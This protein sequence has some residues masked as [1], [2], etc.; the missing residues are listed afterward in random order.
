M[1]SVLP[2]VASGLTSLKLAMSRRFTNPGIDLDVPIAVTGGDPWLSELLAPSAILRPVDPHLLV[3][4]PDGHRP[5]PAISPHIPA[6][7][8]R[9]EGSPSVTRPFIQHHLTNP[10]TFSPPQHLPDD[11]LELAMAASFRAPDGQRGVTP[12]SHRAHREAFR[13]TAIDVLVEM[14]TLIGRTPPVDDSVT[15]VCVSNRPR[16]IDNVVENFSRQTYEAKQLVFVSNSDSFDSDVVRAKLEHLDAVIVAAPEEHSLGE[17]LNEAMS[18]SDS[19]FIAKFDDDDKYGADYLTD[20]INAH[21]YARAGVVG[22]H[23]YHAR[24]EK[25]NSTFLRFPGHEFG[26]TSFLAG[27]TLVIDRKATDGISFSHRSVGEDTGF[28]AECRRRGIDVF[29]ADRFNYLQHR[30]DD[31]TWKVD[32]RAFVRDAIPMPEASIDEE[33]W[34]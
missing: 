33:I 13:S 12:S 24:V 6:C 16:Q 31:N 21:R 10:I 19:R 30:G 25:L 5:D 1:S 27:G 3:V 4:G 29:S 28:L 11:L 2:R 8:Y 34:V 9:S 23:S 18:A 14:L 15:V 22:K 20:M 32:E 7:H 26:Y 17:C